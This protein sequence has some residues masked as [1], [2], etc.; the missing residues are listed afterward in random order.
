M[1]ERRRAAYPTLAWVCRDPGRL[2]AFGLGSGLIRP[3]SGTWG[4]VLAWII[5]VAAAPAATD[6]MIGVFLALAFVWLLGL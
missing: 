4:T 1:R 6:L 5:W 3:A 2:I